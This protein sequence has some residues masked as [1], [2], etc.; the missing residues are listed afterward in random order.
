VPTISNA[1]IHHPRQA[2]GES[3]ACSK[4]QTAKLLQS[5]RL[6]DRQSH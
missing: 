4:L 6:I 3:P 5:D 2:K 1:V